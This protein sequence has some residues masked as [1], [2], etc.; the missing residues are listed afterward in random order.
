[1]ETYNSLLRDFKKNYFIY[2]PL[3]I[4][5]Q[6]CIGSVAV[7]YMSQSPTNASFIFSLA[8]CTITCM[9]Y[10][11]SVLAQLKYK[12]TFNLLLLSLVVNIIVITAYL[13]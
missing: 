5:L 7:F 1:M 9:A 6:S 12:I 3:S 11:A 8:I 10:N 13:I 2:I 4:I